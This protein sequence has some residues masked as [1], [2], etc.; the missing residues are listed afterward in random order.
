MWQEDLAQQQRLR[1][2]KQRGALNQYCIHQHVFVCTNMQLYQDQHSHCCDISI[3]LT[4]MET[5]LQSYPL[6]KESMGWTQ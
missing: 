1:E 5:A 3:V 6:N 2:T 4:S